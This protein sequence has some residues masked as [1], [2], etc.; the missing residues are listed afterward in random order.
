M[1]DN[2]TGRFPGDDEPT[3]HV[4]RAGSW[5]V[6]GD[7]DPTRVHG[8]ARAWSNTGDNPTEFIGRGRPDEETR[9]ADA[10]FAGGASYSRPEP[11][12]PSRDAA[13]GQYWA[14]LTPEEQ[15]YDDRG[16]GRPDDRGYGHSGDRGPG[17]GRGDRYDDYD[18]YDDRRDRRGRDR[19]RGRGR[20]GA[21]TAVVGIVAIVA[22]LALLFWF[23]SSRD[24]GEGTT[25]APTT[26]EA[27]PSPTTSETPTT[28][29][30]TPTENP[31]QDQLDG[32]REEVESLRENP[33]AI[34]GLPG[35]EVTEQQIPDAVG[36]SPGEVELNLRRLGFQD[37]TVYDAQGTPTS[38]LTNLTGTV[39]SIE[40]SAGSVVSTD[41]PIVIRLQ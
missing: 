3:R 9:I 6:P 25:P 11:Q 28:T 14:P 41:T 32:L 33:P 23:V 35:A 10:D 15:G 22:V 30:S 24:S 16:Y 29:E 39:A 27:P 4:G 40:P 26:S 38:T 21:T 12:A 13:G 7:D 1:A 19:D 34:P 31:L 37:I 18:G 17:Y 2:R 5:N 36:K 8:D 20:G